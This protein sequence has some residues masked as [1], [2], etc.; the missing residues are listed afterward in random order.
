MGKAKKAGSGKKGKKGSKDQTPS[1][2]SVDSK[3]QASASAE[4]TASGAQS[5]SATPSASAG[6]GAPLGRPMLP[7]L[8]LPSD[9]TP[10]LTRRPSTIYVYDWSVPSSVNGSLRSLVPLYPCPELRTAGV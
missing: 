7:P 1:K 10:E 4:N 3:K 8:V 5:G 9:L 6:P 2:Q